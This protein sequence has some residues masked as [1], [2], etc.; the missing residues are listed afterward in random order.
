[1]AL[2]AV[3]VLAA[4][5]AAM[6]WGSMAHVFWVMRPWP[7]NFSGQVEGQVKLREPGTLRLAVMG[8]CRD[9][10]AVIDRILEKAKK[11]TDA[12]VVIGDLVS[13]ASRPGFIFFLNDAQKFAG[14][15][16][17]YTGIG[18][19][20]LSHDR[21]GSLYREYFGPDHW[22]WRYHGVLFVMINNVERG[23]YEDQLAWLV[24]TLHD[25]AAAGRVI[26]MM[27]IPPYL[28]DE[29]GMNERR[30]RQLEEVIA[31]YRQRL[32]I[33]A[34]DIH[35]HRELDYGGIPLYITG[36][37]GAPQKTSPPVY[38]WL[39][40]ECAQDDCKITHVN[41]GFLPRDT[42]IP[43]PALSSYWFYGL[44]SLALASILGAV[45][46]IA[47]KPR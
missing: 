28:N 23:V 42:R 8:D 43:G 46:S 6:A 11:R 7:R 36:E 41:M 1:M 38:G 12:A 30:T 25:H 9:N 20:D 3:L 2:S 40:L 37:A 27:H 5:A 34:S 32:T 26:L 24:K 33:I 14:A 35:T 4:A 45:V 16:P 39:L 44:P 21:D 18:N 15:M 31:P 22:W 10:W 17:V 13:G 47:R 29:E 19:H